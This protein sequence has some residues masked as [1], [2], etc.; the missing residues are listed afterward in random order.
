L[1]SLKREV[2]LDG[3][4]GLNTTL[5]QRKVEGLAW[6]FL[7]VELI[8]QGLLLGTLISVHYIEVLRILCG[9]MGPCRTLPWRKRWSCQASSGL[10]SSCCPRTPPDR[11]PHH[12]P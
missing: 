8:S 10:F 3:R 11:G 1:S 5:L 4:I 12:C 6:T 2:S 7:I 9:Y